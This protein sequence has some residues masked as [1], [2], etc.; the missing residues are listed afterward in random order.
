MKTISLLQP[1]ATLVALDT[2]QIETRSWATKYRGPLLIHSSKALPYKNHDLRYQVPFSDVI[3]RNYRFPLGS[4]IA[5]CNLVDCQEITKQWDSQAALKG[6]MVIGYQEFCFGDYTPGRFAWL[7]EGIEPLE[8][9]I[10]AKGQL[11]LWEFDLEGLNI[12]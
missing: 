12:N 4:I 7:L 2:K 11:G 3:P 1:W 5:V 8:K 10:P 6:G 9:P